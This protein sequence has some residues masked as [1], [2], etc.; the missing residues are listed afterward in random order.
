MTLNKLQRFFWK[1][2]P[3][4]W[5]QI[6]EHDIKH[7]KKDTVQGYP[8]EVHYHQ[9]QKEM[10]VLKINEPSKSQAGWGGEK[11]TEM[12]N[13]IALAAGQNINSLGL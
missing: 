7:G 8:V 13:M 9:R 11:K 5:Q 10:D 6:I 12:Q 3:E 4:E 2:F 1:L